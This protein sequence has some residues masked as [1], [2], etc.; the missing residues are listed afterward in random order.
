MKLK[1]HL[2]LIA[3]MITFSLYANDIELKTGG[4]PPPGEQNNPRS[5]CEIFASI[6]EGTVTVIYESQTA[7]RVMV[8]DSQTS[9]TVYD[10]T[11]VPSYSVQANLTS[12][13]SGSYTLYIYAYGIWWH[14]TFA[15]E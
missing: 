4:T 14:G 10:Q 9:T 7:S 5:T 2:F 6:E 13:P 12:L 15:I 3:A 11:Y 8:I 1:H